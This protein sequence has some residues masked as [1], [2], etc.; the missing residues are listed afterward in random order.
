MFYRFSI[1]V[2]LFLFTI[3]LQAADTEKNTKTTSTQKKKSK[4]SKK[5]KKKKKPP[6]TKEMVE[7]TVGNIKKAVLKGKNEDGKTPLK[8]MQI[9]GFAGS[10]DTY[11]KIDDIEKVTKISRRWFE[12][13][14]DALKLL[15]KP[16]ADMDTAILNRNR[17]T[18]DQAEIKYKILL[19]KFTYLIKHPEKAKKKKKRKG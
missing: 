17:K 14:R 11:T 12:K 19:K 18:Y 16:K 5:K 10:F 8:A 4:N 6:F 13:C 15:Y 3:S 2:L 7:F 1:V 9:L